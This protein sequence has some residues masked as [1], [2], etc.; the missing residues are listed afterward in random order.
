M[1]AEGMLTTFIIW[2]IG[3]VLYFFP[4]AIAS[5][6]KHK[7]AGAILMLNLFLGWSCLG[8]IISLVWASTSNVYED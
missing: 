4:A 5:H 7:N 3:F 2:C 8:W 6:R 1:Q